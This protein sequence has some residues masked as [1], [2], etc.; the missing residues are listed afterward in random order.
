MLSSFDENGQLSD[1]T[2]SS[3]FL[4]LVPWS[5]ALARTCSSLSSFSTVATAA[6]SCSDVDDDAPQPADDEVDSE[7]EAVGGSSVGQTTI[8]TSPPCCVWGGDGDE[9]DEYDVVEL[10]VEQGSFVA[11]SSCV[12]KSAVPAIMLQRVELVVLAVLPPPL[13]TSGSF[14]DTGSSMDNPWELASSRLFVITSI[15]S[16]PSGGNSTINPSRRSV[17]AARAAKRLLFVI[18]F[19][20]ASAS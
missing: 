1:D 3:S 14:S 7:S 13:T 20:N 10:L 16:P 17:S 11:L 19:K 5:P 8:G 12:N 2:V 9:E 15:W 4:A 6:S 18:A